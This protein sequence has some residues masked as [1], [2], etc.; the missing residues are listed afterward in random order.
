MTSACGQREGAELSLAYVSSSNKIFSYRSVEVNIPSTAP[1][2]KDIS[3]HAL[4]YLDLLKHWHATSQSG[5]VPRELQPES[6]VT[7]AVFSFVRPSH[8]N[9]RTSRK[10]RSVV[11]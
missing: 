2:A 10:R 11:V 8:R 9:F 6:F 7:S 3:V 1:C 5:E 4:E